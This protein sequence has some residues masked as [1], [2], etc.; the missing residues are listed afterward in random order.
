MIESN[1]GWYL[2]R[3][4]TALAVVIGL[5]LVVAALARRYLNQMPMPGRRTSK[6]QILETSS[7]DRQHRIAV[8]ASGKR[9]FLVGFGNGAV[10][11]VGSWTEGDDKDSQHE[12]LEPEELD[13]PAVF[14]LTG[15]G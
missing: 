12:D 13:P 11:T 5:I 8:V 10:T 9:R 2:L 14:E 1:I 7:L 6:L 4:L 3:S 15:E